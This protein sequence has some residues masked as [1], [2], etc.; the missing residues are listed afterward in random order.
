MECIKCFIDKDIND[1]YKG[2][3][4]YTC[5]ECYSKIHKEWYLKN[6]ENQRQ[7]YLKNK[8]RIK[9]KSKEYIDNNK[10]K[11][12]EYQKVYGK[13]YHKK[14]RDEDPLF[15]MMGNVRNLI[16]NAFARKFTKKSK[17]TTDILC[18]DFETLS[19]H[20]QCQFDDKMNW[21][22]YAIYWEI[23]HIKP[24]SSATN[25]DDI[26]QL[27]HYLN[28]RPLKIQENRSKSNRQL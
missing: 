14:R 5:K 17:K 15:K 25:I 27:N 7:Y 22:N 2:S 4:L 16:K 10:E 11:V 24:L 26:I 6:K 1:F 20:L 8:E 13:K 12:K 23:D 19:K 3:Y 21:E 9:S 28:L 18:C